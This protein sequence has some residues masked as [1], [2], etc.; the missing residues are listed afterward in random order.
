MD[1]IFKAVEFAAIAHNGLFRKG[2]YIPYIIHPILVMQK[3]IENN[4]NKETI[5]AGILHDVVEDTPC[6]L[7][8]IVTNFGNRVGELVG[9]ASEPEE[10][11][12][13]QERKN[14]TMEVLE[15]CDDY[16]ALCLICADKLHNILSVKNDYAK[17]GEQ[18]WKRYNAPKERQQWY[19]QSLSKIFAKK[20]QVKSNSIFL[21]FCKEVDAFF[22]D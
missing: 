18:L 16:D 10:M 22:K 12:S 7:E 19:Y 4:C 1:Q 9:I 2:G 20:N 14:H 3:L 13:W 11:S 21:E 8:E 15:N 6:S 5:V 17:V